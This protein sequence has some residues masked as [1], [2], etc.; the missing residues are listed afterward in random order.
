M[1]A[2]SILFF[3]KCP[4][5]FVLFEPVLDRLQGDERIAL[6]FTGKYQGRGDPALVYRGFNLRGG[7]L[8]RNWRA[9][10]GAYDLYLSPDFRIAGRRARRKVHMFHGFSIRNFAIQERALRFDR[11][12]LIGPYM[13]RRFVAAGLLADDDARLVDV[14]MPKLDPLVNGAFDRARVLE[15]FGLDPALPTVLFAPTWIEGGCLDT[16]GHEIVR[17]LGRLPVNTLIKLHD[18]SFDLR[19]QRHDWARE[20]PPL[21]GPRQVL[22]RGFD[23][24]PCL[25]AADVLISDA[26][27]VANEFLVLDRPLIFFRL[28]EL[29]AAWPSTDRETWGT[30]TGRTIDAPSELDAAVAAALGDPAAGSEVRRAAAADYFFAPGTAA[31]RAAASL[32]RDLGLEAG[33]P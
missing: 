4:M 33:D 12:F 9:R 29:E 2:K 1:R 14:G 20:L 23:S 27:S 31:E 18:N 22:A 30:R 13:R 21:L 26:S 11:L 3:A 10:F 6:H 16:M 19:K 8:V 32:R 7:R 15:G 17:A 28:P 24:N 25:A 5:N